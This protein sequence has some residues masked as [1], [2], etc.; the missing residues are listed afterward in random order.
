MIKTAAYLLLVIIGGVAPAGAQ[1]PQ[2][3]KTEQPVVVTTGEG[4]VKRAPDRAWVTIAAESRARTP[5]DAQRA[6][7]DAMTS[8]T[9][10]LKTSGIAA[11]AIQTTMFDL[12]PEFDYANGKQTLRGYV[13]RNQVQ[14]RVD[15]LPKLGEVIAAVV[16][17][18]ATNISGVRFDLKDRDAAEREAL[19]KAVADARKRADAAVAGAN[20]RV[21]RVTRIEEQREFS[22]GPPR[23]MQMAM[24]AGTAEK[25]AA[26]P[27]E[28][29][30]IE[31]HVRVSL[32]AAIR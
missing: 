28:A 19:R 32:T 5:Q 8:V 26:V 22:P 7:T 29:G 27:I 23:P 16:G 12:Q 3:E 2:P 1:V 17:S 14:V 20:M 21:E 6:N 13:A 30:E 9:Q 11:E 18:G 25:Q 24:R 10:R 4:V 15:E 31:I